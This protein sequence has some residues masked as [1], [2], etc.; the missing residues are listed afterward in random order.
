MRTRNINRTCLI[1]FV[2][3]QVRVAIAAH[4]HDM[5]KRVAPSDAARLLRRP[6]S[7]LLRDTSPHVR[8]ALL[9]GLAETLQVSGLCAGS[10]Q[11]PA[12]CVVYCQ[13]QCSPLA[14]NP[15]TRSVS[16]TLVA[17]DG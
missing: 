15:S 5:A 6:L 3:P 4:L 12:G 11:A 14:G 16:N 9:A 13:L 1:M 17:A 10:C 8:E 7:A 2:L